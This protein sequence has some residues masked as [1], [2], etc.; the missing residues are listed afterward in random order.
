MDW[1]T[2]KDHIGGDTTAENRR[3]SRGLS[4][5]KREERNLTKVLRQKPAWCVQ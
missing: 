3:V 5:V 2:G 1:D 4:W